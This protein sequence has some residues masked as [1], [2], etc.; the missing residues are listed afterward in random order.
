[1][2]ISF[3][4]A[5]TLAGCTAP[6]AVPP[7]DDASDSGAPDTSV[8]DP[9]DGF[10][11]GACVSDRYWTGGRAAPTMNPGEACISCH[12]RQ[13]DAPRFSA[14]GTVYTN[15]D[16]PDD[17]NG[18]EGATVRV[19]DAD[20]QAYTAI[21]NAAGN[22]YFDERTARIV[23]PYTATVTWPDGRVASMGGAQDTGDCNSCHGQ[24]GAQGA[25]G[26]ISRD[27]AD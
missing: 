26:R 13:R 21:S 19:T 15:Y 27:A 20:G 4:V 3:L 9:D 23:P 11:D 7:V 16:E 8:T 5:L 18:V 17:C 2:S 12:Q 6:D 14:A 24:T 10:G 25:P 1:M 22:F